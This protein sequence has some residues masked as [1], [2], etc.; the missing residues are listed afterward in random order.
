LKH[1]DDILEVPSH[2]RPILPISETSDHS[3]FFLVLTGSCYLNMTVKVTHEQTHGKSLYI[4]PGEDDLKSEFVAKFLLPQFT[5]I[6]EEAIKKY[7][8]DYHLYFAELEEEER[9]KNNGI[10]IENIESA[11]SITKNPASI[12][13]GT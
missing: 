7:M 9:I 3:D 12:L 13:F 4:K 8:L 6:N 5:V 2:L 11:S 10:A 1:L